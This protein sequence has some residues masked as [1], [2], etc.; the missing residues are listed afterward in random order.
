MKKKFWAMMLT[1]CMLFCL[2]PLTAKAMSIDI[3][4]TIIG[5]GK[6]TLEV[7]SGDSIDNVKQKIQDKI[8]CPPNQ[9]KLFF[10]DKELQ[11]GRTLADYNIQKESTLKLVLKSKG[12]VPVINGL[13]DQ[14]TYCGSVSFTVSD[15][16]GIASVVVGGNVLTADAEGRY[17]IPAGAGKVTV[18]VTDSV[19]NKT[20]MV[21][22]VND[23]HRFEYI[24]ADV[25][26]GQKCKVCGYVLAAT[27]ALPPE[28]LE[29]NGITVNAGE[30]KELSFRSSAEFSNFL[31]VEFDGKVLDESNYTKREGS[32]II[33]LKPEFVAALS[34]GEHTLKIVSANGTAAAAFYV[35]QGQAEVVQTVASP[36]TGDG[37]N[38]AGLFIMLCGGV[39][40][41]G[42]AVCGR[43]H[44]WN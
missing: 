28:M 16:D 15:D 37:G 14:S 30:S 29:G 13:T 32:T 22:T 35:V 39:G 9:Q 17:T 27:K 11:D 42:L 33:T 1:V 12:D 3:D 5:A 18:V 2:T 43:R 8:G 44:K 31:Y 25:N 34:C 26:S 24:G 40:L 38:V 41:T 10:N 7:E 4:L 21:V 20:E 19:N 36:K 6:L 23:G